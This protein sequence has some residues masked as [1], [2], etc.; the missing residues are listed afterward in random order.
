VVVQVGPAEEG[1]RGKT[2]QGREG[3][4]GRVRGQG[5]GSEGIWTDRERTGGK[6]GRAE[7][8][9]PDRNSIMLLAKGNE[10]RGGGGGYN[11]KQRSREY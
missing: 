9:A 2:A 8:R 11:W 7:R 1:T 5:Q 3:T 4:S 6:T 10:R